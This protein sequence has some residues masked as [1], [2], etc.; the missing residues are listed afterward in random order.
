VAD[1][2]LLL[3]DE[4]TAGLDPAAR[5]RFY[6]LVC[7]LQRARG[8]TVFCASHDIEDVAQHAGRLLLLDRTLRAEGAP[9][10]V[11]ASEILERTYAFPHPH[12]HEPA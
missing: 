9:E 7:D 2:R 3:L 8:L 1:P 12:D 5:A 6:G 11:L 10:D 4:P